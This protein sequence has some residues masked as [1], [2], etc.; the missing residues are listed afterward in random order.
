M[1]F[2]VISVVPEL[3]ALDYRRAVAAGPEFIA[4]DSSYPSLLLQTGW[5]LLEQQDITAAFTRLTRSRLKAEL[6]QQRQ[7]ASR[8][9]A[10]TVEKRIADFRIR[11]D[12]LSDGLLKR[13]LFVVSPGK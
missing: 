8:T 5:V 2:T 12:V 1:V 3:S 13:E 7:L 10:A 4:S 11:L 6:A 9:D